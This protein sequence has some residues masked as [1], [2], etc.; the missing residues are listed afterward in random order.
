MIFQSESLLRQRE[1]ILRRFSK[2][3]MSQGAAIEQLL[4]LWPDDPVPYALQGQEFSAAGDFQAAEASLW[5]ALERNP[6]NYFVY[7]SLGESRLSRDNND[8]IGK[9]L[10]RLALRKLAVAP[11]IP[12][13]VVADYREP[14]EKA[15]GDP[16]DPLTYE[17]MAEATE[18]ILAALPLSSEASDRL[19]PYKLL[20][21]LQAQAPDEV[22]PDL[23]KQILA[24]AERVVPV[25]RAALREWAIHRDR[26][27]RAPLEV[28]V[29]SLGEMGGPDLIP[30]LLEFSS[31]HDPELGLHAHWAIHRL[32]TRLPAETLERLR[33]TAPDAPLPLRC[34]IAEHLVLLPSSPVKADVLTNLLDGITK[35]SHDPD[36]AYLLMIVVYALDEA[37]EGERAERL[38][39]AT[40]PA[41]AGK[42]RKQLRKMLETDFVPSLLSMGIDDLTIED[43]CLDRALMPAGDEEEEDEEDKEEDAASGPPAKP[44]R[45]DPCWCGSG[46]KYKKCHLASDQEQSG[47]ASPSGEAEIE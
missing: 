17:V 45:N 22:N 24:N 42:A 18:A 12:D 9:H 32:A 33:A 13:K 15:G 3:E 7:A 20:D 38:L 6:C 37:G 30:E 23:L 21:E 40:E 39:F 14:I 25:W 28:V 4:A 1:Q 29:A 31:Q 46:K 27:S 11:R 8:P 16:A 10:R 34:V 41:L 26:L 5:K 2:G 35:F 47:G 19:L 43:I 44:G 36:A